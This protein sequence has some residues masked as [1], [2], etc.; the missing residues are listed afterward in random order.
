MPFETSMESSR[1]SPNPLRPYYRPPSTGL[2]QDTRGTT[3]SETHG[4]GPKN[5]SASLYTSS[6]RDIFSDLDYSDYLSESS[7]SA[8]DS[9]RKQID[10]WFYRYVTV[11]L[12]QPFDV[13]KTILQAQS[14]DLDERRN[15]KLEDLRSPQSGYLESVCSDNSFDK[16]KNC[17]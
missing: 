14:Q 17:H 10:E 7:P 6:A 16:A 8:L 12:A 4:L 3:S 15:P 5:G 2:S 13:A 11:L 1:G 9:F